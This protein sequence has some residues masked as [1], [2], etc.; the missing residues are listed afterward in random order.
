MCGSTPQP[1]NPVVV[2]NGSS[3]WAEF[4]AERRIRA[5]AEKCPPGTWGA[6]VE[7]ICVEVVPKLIGVYGWKMGECVT[8][9]IQGKNGEGEQMVVCH[10]DLWNGNFMFGRIERVW[11][12]QSAVETFDGEAKQQEAIDGCPRVHREILIGDFIFDPS[13]TPSNHRL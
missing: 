10:G 13:V 2:D 6:L 7:K 9:D 4:F 1:N 5:V 12:M 8:E 11:G 3:A